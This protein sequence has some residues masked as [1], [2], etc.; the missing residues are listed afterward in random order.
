MKISYNVMKSRYIRYKGIIVQ[1]DR[2]PK[3]NARADLGGGGLG[4]GGGDWSPPFFQ[5][6]SPFFQNVPKTSM[7]HQITSKVFLIYVV[8]YPKNW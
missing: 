2:S 7:S 1:Q 6:V 4:V 8:Y 3:Q 5:A